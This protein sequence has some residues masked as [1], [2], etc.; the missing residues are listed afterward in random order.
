MPP[1]ERPRS[2]SPKQRRPDASIVLRVCNMLLAGGVPYIAAQCV[3]MILLSKTHSHYN[4]LSHHGQLDGVEFFAGCGAVTSAFVGAGFKVLGYELL[5]DPSS[6]DLLSPEGLGLALGVALRI[7]R[8]GYCHFAPVCSTWVWMSRWSTGRTEIAP[9]GE[10]A[11]CH[12]A[13]VM[14]SRVILLVYIL[15]ARGVWVTLE[16]PTSS[17]MRY[18]QPEIPNQ[19][20]IDPNSFTLHY[21]SRTDIFCTL[22]ILFAVSGLRVSAEP[23]DPQPPI[24]IMCY[25]TV[26]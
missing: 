6:M 1:A 20:Q 13:N 8:G 22:C 5:K 16:Q 19:S 23:A 7:R 17:L 14:T 2:R 9:L 15:I 4:G 3:G 10:A 26:I 11:T 12:D 18:R 24:H 25:K 21:A